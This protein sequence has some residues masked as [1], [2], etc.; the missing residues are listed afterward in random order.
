MRSRNTLAGLAMLVV[1]LGPDQPDS[2]GRQRP[3]HGAGRRPGRWHRAR[4][5]RQRGRR[6]HRWLGGAANGVS[7]PVRQRPAAAA[8]TRGRHRR[9]GLRRPSRW[10]GRGAL[11]GRLLPKAGE[12][13]GRQRRSTLRRSAMMGAARAV[14]ASGAIAGWVVR[15]HGIPRGRL[16]QWRPGHLRDHV[17]SATPST[18]AG[19]SPGTH[20]SGGHAASLH[21]VGRWFADGTAVARRQH[22]R[23]K[24]HQQRRATSSET[25]SPRRRQR[26][27][28]AV[29]C[30][31][32]RGRPG[33]LWRRDQQRPRHQ[34]P[35]ADRRLRARCDG[36]APR[37][38]VG[39]GRGDG[40]PQH[41]CCQPT[42]AGCC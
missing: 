35:R 6:R 19:S 34:Q 42:A 37:L 7:D 5:Q 4:R 25:R 8:G 30:H 29:A 11:E 13:P 40:R 31:G 20:V 16:D 12:L 39:C 23:R 1:A 26:N 33:H 36:C 21:L 27:R 28:G 17:R 38:P 2:V 10:L 32:R 3:V 9:R 24:R 22:V 41:V 14:N 15:R 18:T